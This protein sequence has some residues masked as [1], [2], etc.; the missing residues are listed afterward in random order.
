M[1]Y[2]AL[3]QYKVAK[4]HVENVFSISKYLI[5]LSITVLRD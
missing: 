2:E 1:G 5:L 4:G 3:G